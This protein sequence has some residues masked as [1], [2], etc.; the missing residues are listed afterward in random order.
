[1]AKSTRGFSVTGRQGRP[2]I[3]QT[4][5]S[6]STRAARPQIHDAGND[7][8]LP[9]WESAEVTKRKSTIGNELIQ[10]MGEALAHAQGHH[11]GQVTVFDRP[12]DEVKR[13]RERVGL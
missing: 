5:R 4:T 13:I 8:E 2:A 6:A 10:S 1:M 12:A 9:R 3:K 7:A 11:I